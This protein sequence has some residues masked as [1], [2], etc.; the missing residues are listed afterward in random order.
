MGCVVQLRFERVEL[1][2]ARTWRIASAAGGGINTYAVVLLELFDDPVR[3]GVGEAASTVRYAQPVE[4]IERFLQRVDA[5][6]LSFD[7]IPGSM[8]YLES[9]ATGHE[10][11]KCGIN[12]A[13]LDGAARA[14]RRSVCDWLGLGFVEGR[15]VTSFSIGIDVPEVIREKVLAAA[16][17]PILK[18]KVGTED[19]RRSL[20]ALREA[21]PDKVIRVDANEG[22]QSK[23]EALRQIEWLH[24]DGRVEF[25]EQ[26]M[27]ATMPVA[28]WVW[29]KKRSP[30]PLFADESYYHASD[31]GRVAECFH[32]VNVKLVKTAGITGALEALRAARQHGL[33]T[34][35]GCMIESSVLISAGAHLAELADHLDL[36]GNL[37]VTNDP[38]AGPTARDGIL[39]FAAAPEPFGLRVKKRQ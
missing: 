31:A 35:I 32:G 17:Y 6:R 9:V 19:D 3:S 2:F 7:D 21:A 28:D 11:A 34:M 23:E 4:V 25:V 15:H 13:L 18:L 10:A 38:Y 36:D 27:P 12:I 39:S 33:K 26:P 5:R 8:R 37:L 14:A 24:R 29:L 16:P 30:L 20:A 1:R 22:W